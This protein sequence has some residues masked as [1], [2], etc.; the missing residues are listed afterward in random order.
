MIDLLYRGGANAVRLEHF[1]S[2]YDRART[3]ALTSS[4]VFAQAISQVDT[5]E[6]GIS[7]A[8]KFVVQT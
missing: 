7:V 3:A 2:L 8:R 4:F 1:G 6:L 5:R